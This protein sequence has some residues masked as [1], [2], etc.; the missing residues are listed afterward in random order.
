MAEFIVDNNE[1]SLS[2]N[3][4]VCT[5]KEILKEI[6]KNDVIDDPKNE[7]EN[8]KKETNCNTELCVIKS[9]LVEK[10][11][12]SSNVYDIIKKYFKIEGPKLDIEKW[13]SNDDIDKTL[14]QWKNV[15]EW[16]HFH[17]I[18]FQMRD[19][20]KYNTE[21]ART[22]FYELY[23]Q[24]KKTFGC[25]LNTD[26]SSGSGEHWFAFFFDFRKTPFTLEY[27]N[28]SG[29]CPLKEFNNWLNKMQE[30][31]SKQF[32]KITKKVVI[33]KIQHQWDNSSCGIYSLY[34]IYSRLKNI[35]WWHFREN[36]I[37]DEEMH[38]FREF[39]F[40]PVTN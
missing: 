34:Y 2:V 36:R 28:S 16:Y 40:N 37:P 15:S 35:D 8:L 18:P 25:V 21:L 11:I 23:N 4:D 38:K 39:L 24:G 5:P 19:F 33:S 17:H 26:W 29:E 30:K 7:I 3:S 27:F 13:L 31:L 20:E 10:K 22:D 1:C 32:N 12:G 6:T 14:K 9:D